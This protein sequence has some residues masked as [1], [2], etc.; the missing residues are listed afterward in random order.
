MGQLQGSSGSLSQKNMGGAVR[1]TRVIGRSQLYMS[2]ATGH[3]SPN[4]SDGENERNG[5]DLTKAFSSSILWSGGWMV[6]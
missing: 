4:G 2:R 3:R 1:L 6:A 5:A